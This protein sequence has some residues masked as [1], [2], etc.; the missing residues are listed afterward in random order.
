ML[1]LL[2]PPTAQGQVQALTSKLTPGS[3]KMWKEERR[4]WLTWGQFVLADKAI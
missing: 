2:A 4:T 3:L 1:C